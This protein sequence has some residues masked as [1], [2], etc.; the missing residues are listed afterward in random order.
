[1]SIEKQILN[2]FKEIYID[3]EE[4]PPRK[5]R[6]KQTRI[7]NCGFYEYMDGRKVFVTIM[8]STDENKIQQL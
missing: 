2:S 3:L 4:R 7:K 1:M 6:Q 8:I 5:K